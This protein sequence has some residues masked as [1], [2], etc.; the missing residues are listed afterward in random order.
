MTNRP[1]NYPLDLTGR[2]PRNLVRNEERDFSDYP[3]RIFVPAGGV[4]YTDSVV[5]VDRATGRRLRP[6]VDY[7]CLHLHEEATIASGLQAAC[8]IIVSNEEITQIKFD[9]QAVGGI[10]SETMPA[11]RKLLEGVDF[12]T[13]TRISWGTQIYGK[14]ETFPGAPHNHPG[15]QFGDWKRFHV[16]LNNIYHALLNKDGAAWK[17]V[18]D[19]IDSRFQVIGETL[20]SNDQGLTQVQVTNMIQRELNGKATTA[21]IDQ[22]RQLH[23]RDKQELEREL[24][25]LGVAD[26]DLRTLVD[27]LSANQ[28]RLNTSPDNEIV[29]KEG[30]LYY[31]QPV[32]PNYDNLW[33]DSWR[34]ND[35][36]GDGS[37]AKPFKSVA[38]AVQILPVDYKHTT[39]WLNLQSTNRF[40]TEHRLINGMA[41]GAGCTRVFKPW[42][43]SV[44]DGG[45]GT[46]EYHEYNWF[47]NYGAEHVSLHLPYGLTQVGG[48][49]L[50]R[51]QSFK[52]GEGSTLIFQGID[53][54]MDGM[55]IDYVNQG[56]S[57]NEF[58]YNSY[59]RGNGTVIFEGSQ[60]MRIFPNPGHANDYTDTLYRLTADQIINRTYVAALY[61]NENLT[62][63]FNASRLTYGRARSLS[64]VLSPYGT[65][66]RR[67]TFDTNW[68]HMTGD[69]YRGNPFFSLKDGA[70]LNIY[71]N[72]TPSCRDDLSIVPTRMTT[73]ELKQG[74]LSHVM[75]YY[76]C[77]GIK[78]QNGTQLNVHSTEPLVTEDMV[79]AAA[80]NTPVA[81][82]IVQSSVYNQHYKPGDIFHSTANFSL[83]AHVAEHHGY[84][85]W[86][87][88][89][90]GRVLV[91]RFD[92]GD[93]SDDQQ[94]PNHYR[95]QGGAF[96]AYYKT[97]SIAEIPNHSHRYNADD[98]AGG[99]ST[100]RSVGR[101]SS[102]KGA[103][104]PSK[105]YFTTQ[106]YPNETGGGQAFELA[107]PS[108]VVDQW[109]RMPNIDGDHYLHVEFGTN[110][111]V[112]MRLPSN[113]SH[114]RWLDAS[115]MDIQGLR[116]ND[117]NNWELYQILFTGLV[118][119]KCYVY[120][121]FRH[122]NQDV[123][124]GKKF[125]QYVWD[126]RLWYHPSYRP[127]FVRNSTNDRQGTYHF[128]IA[129][130]SIKPVEPEPSEK[131]TLPDGTVI[132][133]PSRNLTSGRRYIVDI[134]G[135]IQAAF[136]KM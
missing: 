120:M 34:G 67:I 112:S 68:F 88:Y 116:I 60:L 114:N 87:K 41:I 48:R 55:N 54:C 36:T 72:D 111:E 101:D 26:R 121:V 73:R 104:G 4:F 91:G 94:V 129:C 80:D 95:L 5:M 103:S 3:H 123:R 136:Y 58:G 92:N 108:M 44:S 20:D 56:Y 24:A 7:K 9:Y 8:V 93:W 42:K 21:D 15:T 35:D 85:I 6:L 69:G 18:F 122:L 96:G 64:H 27:T 39:I 135:S 75:R 127:G 89:A 53:V 86:H 131:Q 1:D 132:T 29:I 49:K 105:E 79:G 12:N 59:F 78:T 74:N 77:A 117:T 81:L 11:L 106:D 134:R 14:P 107:Q 90:P 102:Q 110:G 118:N 128:N 98:Q 71:W 52:L 38:K 46:G 57:F 10:Y 45:D 66:T 82:K 115:T 50:A 28:L 62:F 40:D 99:W 100:G 130:V 113:F 125:Y 84:G 70:Q 126:S 76:V 2:S 31:K 16:A 25:K 33:V 83:P 61:P 37:K 32:P 13:L 23:E 63:Y 133:L 19:Y 47:F 119:E 30:G 51:V 109:I 97:L 124:N 43:T 65:I 22:V 17:A